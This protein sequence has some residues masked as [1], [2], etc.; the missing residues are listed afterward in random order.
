MVESIEKLIDK[1]I[2]EGNKRQKQVKRDK[3]SGKKDCSV[4]GKKYSKNFIHS[5]DPYM[6]EIHGKITPEEWYCK[7]C[8]QDALDEI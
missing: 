5:N 7:D 6:E 3:K 1:Y 8:F 2:G 4:C